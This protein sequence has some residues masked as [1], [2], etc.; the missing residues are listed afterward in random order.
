[1][2]LTLEVVPGHSLGPFRLMQDS[3]NSV[4]Q[5]LHRHVS[6]NRRMRL[7]NLQRNNRRQSGRSR[8][9]A[10][11]QGTQ[12]IISSII[13]AA[14]AELGVVSSSGSGGGDHH[15]HFDNDHFDTYGDDDD[16]VGV[17]ND[18][19]DYQQQ[20]Q[21]RQQHYFENVEILY[22]RQQPLEHDLVLRLRNEAI[23]LRFE[24]RTQ[25]LKRID[26]H[27]A[28]HRVQLAYQLDSSGGGGGRSQ[29]NTAQDSDGDENGSTAPA[30][31][32][33]IFCTPDMD[34]TFVK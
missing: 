24:P 9:S 1:M 11:V 33:T 26:L 17:G 31:S 5:Y 15:H 30:S 28:E 20:H 7:R 29:R 12:N 18:F 19:D 16:G 22:D 6:H 10:A 2:V 14:G 34:P 32:S 27:I 13:S 23:T 4:I 8:T 25:R 21:Q 3:V